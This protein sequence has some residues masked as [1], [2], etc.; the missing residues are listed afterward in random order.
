[1]YVCIH[2]HTYTYI[3]TH[4]S[5]HVHTRARA[6]THICSVCVSSAQCGQKK[7][8]KTGIK[9]GCKPSCGLWELTP[10]PLQSN[11]CS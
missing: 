8:P 10:G 2:K 4:I 7:A 1:M 11:E 9:N 5:T 6:H 3:L